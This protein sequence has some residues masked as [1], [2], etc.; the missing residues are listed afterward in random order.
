M[1]NL[2]IQDDSTYKILLS[3]WS[4]GFDPNGTSKN[5]RGSIHITSFSLL[6]HTNRNDPNLSFP[7]TVSKDNINHIDIRRNVYDDLKSLRKPT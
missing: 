5:N 7:S 1:Q 6:G 4:D 2:E 3:E